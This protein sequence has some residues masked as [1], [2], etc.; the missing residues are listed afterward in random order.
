MAIDKIVVIGAS[1]MRK[2]WNS[3]ADAGSAPTR[4][5]MRTALLAKGVDLPF[6]SYANSGDTAAQTN[7]AIDAILA[8]F[9]GELNVEFL[10]HT[11]GNEFSANGTYSGWTQSQKDDLS[12]EIESI[13][14]KIIAAGHRVILCPLSYRNY[15][16]A[17]ADED[18]GSKGANEE[19]YYP[20]IETYSPDWWDS[21]NN[22][23]IMNIYKVIKDNA[24]DF[25][26]G[27]DP[28]HPAYPAGT[29]ILQQYFAETLT[30]NAE[31]PAW[32]G[33]ERILCS[34]SSS[35]PPN[36]NAVTA[37]NGSILDLVDSEGNVISG[38][39]FSLTG[40]AAA[41]S[42]QG[43][44]NP[45]NISWNV[46]HRD[47]T[48]HYVYTQNTATVTISLGAGYA[49][50]TGDVYISGAR[51]SSATDRVAEFT[52]GENSDT[53]D[54][55]LDDPEFAT[56]PFTLDSGGTLTIGVAEAAG[57]TYA[58]FSGALLE[59]DSDTTPQAP[60]MPSNASVSINEGSTAP[61]GTYAA[62]SGTEP[63]AYSLTGANAGL[64]TVNSS[65]AQ[66]SP[67]SGIAYN[68]G[69]SNTYVVNVVG[70]NSEGSDSTQVT[71][72]VLEVAAATPPAISS[73]T[74]TRAGSFT[75]AGSGFTGTSAVTINGVAA[76]SF[77]VVSD[78]SI[79]GVWPQD[80]NAAFNTS[81]NVVVT[82]PDGSDTEG[83]TWRG[84]VGHS[85]V[86]LTSLSTSGDI[87]LAN[88]AGIFTPAVVAGNVVSYRPTMVGTD[89][90]GTFSFAISA[91]GAFVLESGAPE[92]TYQI[93]FGVQD[94]S[95]DYAWSGTVSQ[96]V[97]IVIDGTSNPSN[98]VFVPDGPL[99]YFDAQGA[100]QTIANQ[101]GVRVAVYSAGGIYSGVRVYSGTFN[102]PA[103]GALPT[104]D[105]DLLGEVGDTIEVFYQTADGRRSIPIQAVV[106]DGNV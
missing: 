1:I 90:E 25:F 34:V 105:S 75:I 17:I 59:L 46:V 82:N 61:I 70:T 73:V 29:A 60:V 53:V 21:V 52:V 76:T 30:A 88:Q 99:Q 15:T 13:C 6:Y 40:F 97:E 84:P 96:F 43:K 47:V 49:G 83:V 3:D 100:L 37:N 44:A 8:D 48:Q 9:A 80:I 67:A 11:G 71:V 63:I 69:G 85:Q 50:R 7:S 102:I 2:V 56:L 5:T 45:A 103:N 74:G 86:T 58:Y 22:L 79:T 68:S 81:V 18:N 20:L 32:D 62:V 16:Y 12:D 65:T 27:V 72:T 94:A 91:A 41:S 42:N 66:L 24:N 35:L 95:D 39:S 89:G 57:S 98:P 55:A 64:F 104:I 19:I 54:A 101:V 93:E 87:Y 28:I 78:T 10:V 31:L 4:N 38:S 33:K 23:P 51:L 36:G 92:G 106:T 26:A 77:S 14:Q